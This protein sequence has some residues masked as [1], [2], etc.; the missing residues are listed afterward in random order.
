ME[1]TADRFAVN[2]THL[3]YEQAGK[4]YLCISKK[5]SAI[6]AFSKNIHL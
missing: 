2:G 3:Y 5:I 1:H 6:P 4:L